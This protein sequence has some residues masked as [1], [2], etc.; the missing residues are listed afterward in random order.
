MNTCTLASSVVAV[1]TAVIVASLA[2]V[3]QVCVCCYLRTQLRRGQH[4]GAITGVTDRNADD[5]QPAA[6]EDPN[7]YS[8]EYPN[9]QMNEN[10]AYRT[11]N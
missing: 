9:I 4:G 7:T 6:L 8:Y 11:T 2:A 1:V 10:L 5:E 3:L